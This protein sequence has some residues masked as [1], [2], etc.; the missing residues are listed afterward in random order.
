MNPN[1]REYPGWAGIHCRD[2]YPGAYTNGSRVV[3]VAGDAKD[4]HA[5]GTGATVLG[6]MGHPEVGIGYFVEWDAT[7][8]VAVFVAAVKIAP[9]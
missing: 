5:I 2:Q 3:K 6:S 7:P 9:A 4:A 8:R 1:L